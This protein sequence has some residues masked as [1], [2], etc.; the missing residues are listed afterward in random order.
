MVV[1]CIAR[2]RGKG[3]RTDC[4][5]RAGEPTVACHSVSRLPASIL[6]D[7]AGTVAAIYLP[8]P[9][10]VIVIRLRN[11]TQSRMR[12]DILGW[13]V[14]GAGQGMGQIAATVQENSSL[15]ALRRWPWRHGC[16]HLFPFL[17][18]SSFSVIAIHRHGSDSVKLAVIV[19]PTS[20]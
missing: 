12:F 11:C 19:P 6:G 18:H 10:F 8:L 17:L 4:G 1:Y 3:W 16:R 20:S 9:S 2:V 5:N 13:S 15:P 14:N 7:L